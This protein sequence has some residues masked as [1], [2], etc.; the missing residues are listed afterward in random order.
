MQSILCAKLFTTLSRLV[1][2][3]RMS[4][5]FT[6]DINEE[7]AGK[8]SLQDAQRLIRS[9]S[10]PHAKMAVQTLVNISQNPRMNPAARV[11][12]ANSILDRAFGKPEQP[13]TI[14]LPQGVGKTGVMLIPSSG[15]RDEWLKRAQEHHQK[16]LSST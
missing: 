15:G 9:L 4:E 16:M 13:V 3:R 8:M 1:I 6:T 2:I 11:A 14:P 10:I 12:A 7:I 5:G